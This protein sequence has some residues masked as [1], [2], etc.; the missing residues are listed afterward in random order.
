MRKNSK[1]KFT[2]NFF[3]VE[4]ESLSLSFPISY[5]INAYAQEKRKGDRRGD[6]IGKEERKEGKK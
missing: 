6:A 4:S 3:Y 5:A 2:T 1:K